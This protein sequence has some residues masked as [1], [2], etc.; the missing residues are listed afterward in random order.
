MAK[1]I[2]IAA[3]RGEV[4]SHAIFFH[5]LGGDPYRTWRFGLDDKLLWPLWLANDIKRLAVWTIGYEAPISRWRGSAMHLT[6]RATNVLAMLLAEP[7]LRIHSP[8]AE[9]PQTFGPSRAP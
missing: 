1:L 7:K 5:G 3:C 8:P 9:S 2:A 4:T 6:D